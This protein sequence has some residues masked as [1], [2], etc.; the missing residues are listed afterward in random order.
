MGA[1]ADPEGR[2]FDSLDF[3]G[4]WKRKCLGTR[5]ELQRWIDECSVCVEHGLLLMPP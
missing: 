1:Q 2:I 3:F 5:E 4:H